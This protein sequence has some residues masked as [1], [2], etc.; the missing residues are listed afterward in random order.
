MAMDVNHN[1][2]VVVELDVLIRAAPGTVWQL[3]TGIDRWSDWNPHIERAK[4]RGPLRV[5]A[6]F[7]WSTAG[8][9]ITST[10]GEFVPQRRI[11]WGGRTHDIDGL[12]VWTFTPQPG[13]VLVRT[14]ESWDGDP[15]RA[16]PANLRTALE[17]GKTASGTLRR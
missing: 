14:E 11:A 4:L 15:V 12:H 10:I 13:G 5:G 16:D 7:D 8:L 6:S 9:E 2:P 17:G 1:A 3:H